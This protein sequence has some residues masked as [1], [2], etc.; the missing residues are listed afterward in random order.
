MIAAE[1]SNETHF[2]VLKATSTRKLSK[3]VRYYLADEAFEKGK[4]FINEHAYKTDCL[5][6]TMSKLLRKE[7]I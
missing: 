6:L 7:G 2:L 5:T 3:R 1:R 4:P